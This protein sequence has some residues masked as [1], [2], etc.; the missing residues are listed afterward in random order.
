MPK[1]TNPY[2]SPKTEP[3]SERPLPSPADQKV[4]EYNG[5]SLQ[6]LIVEICMGLLLLFL[7]W[8]P[9]HGRSTVGIAFGF[10]TA[11]VLTGILFSGLNLAWMIKGAI[12]WA[13]EGRCPWGLPLSSV[14]LLGALGMLGFGLWPF[15]WRA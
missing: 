3:P 9:L 15:F 4:R 14:L 11:S 7:G 1:E 6:L 8:A 13:R 12:L 2:E 5:F 10:C